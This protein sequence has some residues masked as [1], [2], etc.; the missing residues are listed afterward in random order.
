LFLFC[1]MQGDPDQNMFGE[2]SGTVRK[3]LL[4]FVLVGG[5]GLGAVTFILWRVFFPNG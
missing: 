3:W 2:A 1:M 5:L 4:M